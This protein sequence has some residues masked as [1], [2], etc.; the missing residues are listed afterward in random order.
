MFSLEKIKKQPSTEESSR[1]TGSYPLHCGE[2]QP[3]RDQKLM[4]QSR[5]RAHRE[6]WVMWGT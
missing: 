5:D 1:F 3:C 6:M 2:E 4:Q